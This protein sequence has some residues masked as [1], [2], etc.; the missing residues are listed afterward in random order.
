MV[1]L[2]NCSI[3]VFLGDIQNKKVIMYGAGKRAFFACE[4]WKFEQRISLIIDSKAMG[5]VVINGCKIP[6]VNIESVDKSM[7]YNSV[8]FVS[9]YYYAMEMIDKLDRQEIFDGM[10]CYVLN[11][12]RD[13]CRD[14]EMVLKI[15]KP[16][17]PKKIHYCWFGKSKMSEIHEKC[18][19]SWRKTCPDYEIIR[20][21]ENNYDYKKNRY[22]YEAYKKKKW[23]FVPDYARLD[24]VLNEGGVYL[25]TD[26]FLYKSL[27]YL[28]SNEMFC[29]ASAEGNSAFGLGFGAV[30]GCSLIKE[31]RDVYDDVL[32]VEEDGKMNLRACSYYQ[33]PVLRLHGFSLKN[34]YQKIGNIVYYPSSVMN[35][36]GTGGVVDSTNANTVGKHLGANSWMN[37]DDRDKLWTYKKRIRDRLLCSNI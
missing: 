29:C 35:P 6:V 10:S 18:L 37:I 26:V 28:I 30:K 21:D 27:D 25:D 24:I 12:M 23:G 33:D 8:L 2:I 19:E 15:N 20:W 31:L 5:E 7:I 4:T 14:D 11:I 16:I 22:M 3:D 9:S 36:E 34:E 1:K 13:Y 32:F 17:I